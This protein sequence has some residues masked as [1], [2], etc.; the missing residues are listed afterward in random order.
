MSVLEGALQGN[1]RSGG[2]GENFRGTWNATTNQT[3]L[4]V[5]LPNPPTTPTYAVGDYWQVTTAGTQFSITFTV[6]DNIVVIQNGAALAWSKQEGGL[7][8]VVGP[9]TSF[10]NATALFSDTTGKAIKNGP[11]NNFS[12]I[13]APTVS[14]DST[15][16]YIAGSY[17]INTALNEVYQCTSGSVGAAV[18]ISITNGFKG[19]YL[20]EAALNSALPTGQNGWWAIL[21]RTVM[22]IYAWIPATNSW[23]GLNSNDT[24]LKANNLSDLA[25]VAT[26]KTNLGLSNSATNFLGY[27]W[28]LVDL[29]LDFPTPAV[30]NYVWVSAE[31]T[32]YEWNGAAWVLA[33]DAGPLTIYNNL[34]DLTNVTTAVGNLGL[35]ETKYFQGFFLNSIAL[36]AAIPTGQSFWFAFVQSTNSVWKWITSAWVDQGGNNACLKTANLSDVSNTAT[37]LA[38]LGGASASTVMLKANNCSD[39]ANVTTT[40]IN[41][42]IPYSLYTNT[43][44]VTNVGAPET[45]LMTYTLPAGKL[46]NAGDR[47]DI[48]GQLFGAAN[49]NNKTVKLY[50][51]GTAVITNSSSASG[52]VFDINVSIVRVSATTIAFRSLESN[53][54]SM[55]TAINTQ[56]FTLSSSQVIKF[57][58]DATSTADIT[59]NYMRVLFT[60]AAV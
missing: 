59:Q 8:D 41:L 21:T 10:N 2:T 38:N 5:T 44:A 57:T 31:A 20:S 43:V 16:G 7:G 4:G 22:Y 17:W 52:Q 13:V 11:V 23:E 40:Q 39:V 36:N 46:A 42:R 32:Y 33:V 12:A 49:A 18:W 37:A 56:T 27:S 30:G 24:L 35:L 14:N 29:P 26:A 3:N 55:R 60:P 47:I 58:G 45:D 1:D 51:G 53:L 9:E 25:N 19:Y 50:F 54:G 6:G 34:S 28:R 48:E 15:Q